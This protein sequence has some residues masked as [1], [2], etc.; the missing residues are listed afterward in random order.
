MRVEVRSSI[1]DVDP[2]W[3][4]LASRD[5]VGL[6]RD[7]LRA[8]ER[9]GINRIEPFYL[10]A[11]EGRLVSGIAYCFLIDMDFGFLEKRLP[12]ETLQTLREWHPGF[13]KARLLECGFLTGLGPAIAAREG[14]LPE[15][16]QAVAPELERIA[17]EAGAEFV[18]VRD[19][20]IARQPE[21]EGFSSRG[22]QPL[23][24]YPIARM[25]LRWAS[26]DDYLAALK[27]STRKR[28]RRYLAQVGPEVET[29]VIASFGH[30][31]PRLAELWRKTHA[32]AKDYSHEE[33][34]E[35]F[36]EEIDRQLGARSHVMAVKQ[37]AR[38]SPSASAWSGTG[39][40]SP[41]MPGSTTTAQA[42][43]ST[44]CSR[45]R[46][47]ATPSSA[48]CGASTTGSPPT[49]PSSSTA[50]RAIRS[51]TWSSMSRT[52]A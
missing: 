39:S 30:L 5:Q 28:L 24:G 45:W 11:N 49:T 13:M 10:V 16:C 27:C 15:V 37:G 47:C 26:F 18:L 50:S 35:G 22:F 38:S 4:S 42:T 14:S 1:E 40:T 23:L 19:V 51:C 43:S 52:R 17:R 31:A 33:L 7:H 41:P 44:C 21:L 36:F 6:E 2:A 46:S 9:S 20:P 3:D 48:G 8:V 34:S 32:R 12:L 29:E 25:A